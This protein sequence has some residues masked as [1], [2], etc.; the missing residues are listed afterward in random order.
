ME[1][2]LGELWV[3]F[4]SKGKESRV[5]INNMNVENS[6]SPDNLVRQKMSG[7]PW[8]GEDREEW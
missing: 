4:I 2:N 1:K 7:K 5:Y 8:R 6:E 3:S